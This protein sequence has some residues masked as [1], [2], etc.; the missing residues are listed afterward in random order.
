MKK[1]KYET[2]KPF[3][4]IAMYKDYEKIKEMKK[5]Q[6]QERY[7]YFPKYPNEISRKASD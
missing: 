4:G 1:D 6:D 7:L 3:T 5:L 2:L